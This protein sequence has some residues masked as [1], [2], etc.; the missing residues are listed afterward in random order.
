MNHPVSIDIMAGEMFKGHSLSYNPVRF[1]RLQLAVR[2]RVIDIKGRLGD[3]PAIRI[4]PRTGGLHTILYQSTG[5]EIEYNTPQKFTDFAEQEGLGW[6]DEAHQ[7]RGLPS[8]GF[9]ET[10]YRYCKSLLDVGTGGGKDQARGLL[11]ELI[12]LENPYTFEGSHLPVKLL[13]R[14]EPAVGTQVSIFH[15]STDGAA[16]RSIAI[17]DRFGVARIPL[18][19]AGSYLLSAVLVE[20]GESNDPVDPVWVS[21]WASLTFAVIR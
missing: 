15:R 3:L 9:T 10:F 13:W 7:R 1:S 18:V 21:H 5:S 16:I 14:G 20:P 4:T 19:D 17:T 8:S 12:T 11:A 6:L 2:D